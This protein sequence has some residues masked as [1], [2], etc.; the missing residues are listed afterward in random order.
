MASTSV[1]AVLRADRATLGFAAWRGVA[2]TLLVRIGE[3]H[4]MRRAMAS[5][6]E[7]DARTLR[8]IAVNRCEIAFLAKQGHGT[9]R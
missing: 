9:R 1:H 6:Q 5:L 4:R 2:D 7:I 3:G 8:D